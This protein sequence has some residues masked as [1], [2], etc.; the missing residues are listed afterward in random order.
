MT[1]LAPY[2]IQRGRTYYVRAR[3]PAD[4]A[5]ATGQSHF[6]R[7]LHTTDPRKARGEAAR[8]LTVAHR[9]W[10]S[11]RRE[12]AVMKVKFFAGKDPAAYTGQ[13]YEGQEVTPAQLRRRAKELV[14]EPYEEP[15]M[16]QTPE[17]VERH[18]MA[19]ARMIA[20]NA[21]RDHKTAAA[22]HLRIAAMLAEELREQRA[23]G[24]VGALPARDPYEGLDRE[25]ATKPFAEHLKP[26]LATIGKR[27]DSTISGYEKTFERLGALLGSKATADVDTLD[28]ERFYRSLVDT[29]TD[30]G[31]DK[32]EAYL[33]YDTIY[34]SISNVRAF[35][36]WAV[37]KH[38]AHDNPARKVVVWKETYEDEAEDGPARR[39]FTPD[40]L[41][42]IF[43]APLFTGC[44][45]E[46]RVYEPGRVVIR[47]HK[48]FFPLV[49][50]LSGM[51]LSEIR[52]LEF[53]DLITLVC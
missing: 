35:Y 1:S 13:E 22:D 47:N 10:D 36:K 7:S 15:P 41:T 42:R 16:P 29:K 18:I 39:P 51:R 48:F 8:L 37:S 45:S 21:A 49:G 30:K 23:R 40:E 28:I 33:A 3:V 52:Q 2:I 31:P 14:G 24:T 32:G 44:K 4:V 46:N 6:V 27:S 17:E 25:G 34:K 12:V 50:F 5:A 38:Y 11:L 20:D 26:Y 19:H 53:E 9:A 43:D